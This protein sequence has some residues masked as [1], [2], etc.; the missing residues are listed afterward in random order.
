MSIIT[1]HAAP[2]RRGTSKR[3]CLAP[4]KG[5][6]RSSSGYGMASRPPLHDAADGGGAGGGRGGHLGQRRLLKS[7]DLCRDHGLLLLLLRL[8]QP[9]AEE[10]RGD[11]RHKRKVC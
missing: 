4:S 11:L 1:A 5:L 9:H 3:Q 8:A 2:Q 7:D 10:L 6:C